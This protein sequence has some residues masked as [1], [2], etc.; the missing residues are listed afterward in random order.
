[1]MSR[2]HAV[3]TW[4]A[5]EMLQASCSPSHVTE[6]PPTPA[7]VDTHAAYLK[8]NAAGYDWF[9][10]AA[11]GY[12]GVPLVLL[13]ALPDLAP[14]IWGKA[15][16]EFARFGYLPN[17]DGPL[18]LGLSWDSMDKS[19]TPQPLHP[20]ALTCGACHIGRVK[21]DDG[22]YMKLVG[23][24]NTE[25][26]VRMWRKA[27]ELTVHK[28][29][30]TPSDVGATAGRLKAAIAERP[31]NYFFRSVGGVSAETEAAERKYVSDNAAAILTGFAGKILLG[32]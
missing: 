32:E 27:F 19:V 15:D 4:L 11:D 3:L 5:V 23:G 13:R 20:V 12:G 29:L 18:P 14:E 21:L 6:A 31:P 8:E 10:N 22:S 1:M 30:S 26:D 25:F 9:A 24:P 17:P 2:R 7:R 28:Y 16:E